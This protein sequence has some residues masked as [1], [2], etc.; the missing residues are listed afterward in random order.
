MWTWIAR[1]T[2]VAAFFTGTAAAQEAYPLKPITLVLPYAAGGGADLMA[3][4]LAESLRR[5]L[6]QTVTVQNVGGA[7]GI[8]GSRQVAQA[9]P[10]GYTLL[11]N[12]IGLA[13]APALYRNLQFDPVRSYEPVG[14]FA[15]IPMLVVAGKGFAPASAGELVEH[16]RRQKDKVTFASSGMGSGTHLCAMLFEKAVGQKVTMVQYKGSAPAYVDVQSGRVDLLCDSTGGSVA[17]VKGGGVKAYLVTGY[18][19]LESLPMVPS[20]VEAGLKDLGLMVVWYGIFAPAGTPKPVVERLSLAL[21]AAVQ[22][23]TV[24]TQLAA[25]DATLVDVRQAT[26]AALAEK[27]STQ[28]ALWTQILQTAG[29][30]PQ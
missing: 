4:L 27:M 18:R 17:Q 29:V 21:Q 14:L 12:H 10:D 1:V 11:M 22:D 16:V 28:V 5:S 3:R 24:G 26:P 30:T 25:W 8:V 2:L 9:T 13:T 7:G 15:E 23:R 19:R 6:G 20:A